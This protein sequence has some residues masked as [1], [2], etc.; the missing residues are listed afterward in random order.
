MGA[1]IAIAVG[2]AMAMAVAEVGLR[3][4]MPEWRE[5]N[6]LNFFKRITTANHVTYSIGK[7][8]FEGYFAQNN[9]DFRH[10]IKINDF[11]LRNDEPVTAAQN[12][13]WVIGDSM[14]F[15]WG[16][17]RH[18]TYTAVIARLSGQ[19]TY[20]VAGPGNDVCGYQAL[21]GRMPDGIRPRA[22]IVGLILENDVREYDCRAKAASSVR[23]ENSNSVSF[24]NLGRFKKTLN[25]YSAA[26]NVLAASLK[27][28]PLINQL[29]MSLGVVSEQHVIRFALDSAGISQHVEKT[30]EAVAELQTMLPP[31]IPFA[32]L[33][34]PARF[35]IRDNHPF[36]AEVRQKLTAS[37]SARSI[38]VI[39]PYAAFREMGFEAV[40]FQHDGHWTAA[41]HRAAG[42]AAAKWLESQ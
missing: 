36:Y 26:Y 14:A 27:R 35:E 7:P 20:S 21:I 13:L 18:E 10:H 39:D 30:V 23:T 40:H 19:P 38:P 4:A 6:S 2:L 1:I 15:G 34:A 33:L 28:V 17:E 37:L 9:G 22:A 16:V 42:A 31:E 12:R 11:G 3:I 5:F 24:F 8:G 25:T 41:G 29:L 32:V